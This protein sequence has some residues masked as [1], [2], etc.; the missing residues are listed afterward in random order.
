VYVNG[1][2]CNEARRELG[3]VAGLNMKEKAYRE[4]EAGKVPPR[5]IGII[6][7]SKSSYLKLI[8]LFMKSLSVSYKSTDRDK[9]F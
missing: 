2:S 9:T 8:Y 1:V 7:I 5:Q 3:A 6:A 4:A